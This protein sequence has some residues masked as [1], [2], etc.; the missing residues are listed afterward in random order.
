MKF[1]DLGFNNMVLDERIVAVVSPD[2]APAKR[3]VA[4]AKDSS[5]AIDCTGGRK[6]KCVIITDSDHVILSSLSPQVLGQ[7][8]NGKE[9][10]GGNQ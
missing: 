1:V 4:E 9:N 7:R 3:I 5:R 8:L 6:T 2:S 10:D